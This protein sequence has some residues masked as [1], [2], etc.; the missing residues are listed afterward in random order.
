MAPGILCFTPEIDPSRKPD[1]I[2]TLITMH[3]DPQGQQ[4]LN[5]FRR[6]RVHTFEAFQI[7]EVE[8]LV[9]EHRRLTA[10][11]RGVVSAGP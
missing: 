7:A 6:D 9:E 4:V 10:A 3:E 8:K 11:R 1:I 2:N 5:L